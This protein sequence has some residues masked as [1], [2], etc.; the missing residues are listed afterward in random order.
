MILKDKHARVL[1]L[2]K[3]RPAY[4]SEI[5]KKTGTT[6]VYVTHFVSSLSARRLVVAEAMGKKKM[7]KL[8]EKGQEVATLLEELRRR[9]E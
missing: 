7:V 6:Y 4:L 3:V 1:L 2:L 9:L 8:T 5:A